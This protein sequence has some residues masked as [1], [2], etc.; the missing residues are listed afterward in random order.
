MNLASNIESNSQK[1]LIF[2]ETSNEQSGNEVKTIPFA[3]A[4]K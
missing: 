4:L 3:I 1:S 2:V